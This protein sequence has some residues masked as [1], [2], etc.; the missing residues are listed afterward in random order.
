[1]ILNHRRLPF[2][3]SPS[4]FA[5]LAYNSMRSATARLLTCQQ[6]LWELE[7]ERV[8]RL[9]LDAVDVREAGLP[10]ALPSPAKTMNVGVELTR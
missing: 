8:Q 6:S 5:P 3:H 2:R 9:G 10:V 4:G 1:M 7:L